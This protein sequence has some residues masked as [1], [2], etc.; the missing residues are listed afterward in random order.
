MRS[1]RSSLWFVA[2]TPDVAE[3]VREEARTVLAG[4]RL[5]WA[6]LQ[7]IEYTERLVRETL[8]LRPPSWA[9]FR[10]AK[11][12]A[13]LRDQRVREGDFVLLLQWALHRDLRYFD[14]P[15]QFDPDR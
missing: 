15:E 13:P 5:S 14:R 3:R 9:I 6:H 12:E 11:V 1:D 7:E 8:R 4:D 2:N 10:E